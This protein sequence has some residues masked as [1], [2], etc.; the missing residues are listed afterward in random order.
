MLVFK[1]ELMKHNVLQKT[2]CLLFTPLFVSDGKCGL[3]FFSLIN[4]LATYCYFNGKGAYRR[5]NK[6]ING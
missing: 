3:T 5:K 1:A 4:F 2:L 6:L